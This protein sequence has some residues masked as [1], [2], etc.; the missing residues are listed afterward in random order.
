MTSPEGDAIS[1]AAI[2]AELAAMGITHVVSVPDGTIG[3]W[4]EAIR[5]HPGLRLV[6]VCREGE[7]WAVAMGLHLGGATPLVLIQ[8][9]GLFESGDSLRNVLHDWKLPIFSIIGYRSY[10]NQDTLP[11]DTCLLFTEPVLDAW[12][13]DWRLIT[14]AAQFGEIRAHYERC[15]AANVPGAIVVAEGRA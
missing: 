2:A 5:A 10:L 11:G 7:A 4:H 9:T 1:G 6:S 15:R 12:K 13:I 8:C 14:G 3:A